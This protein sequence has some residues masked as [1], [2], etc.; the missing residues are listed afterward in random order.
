MMEGVLRAGPGSKKRYKLP[1]PATAGQSDERIEIVQAR[2][3]WRAVSGPRPSSPIGSSAPI[4]GLVIGWAALARLDDATFASA[5]PAWQAGRHS[6][7][8]ALSRTGARSRPGAAIT[9]ATTRCLFFL[10][11]GLR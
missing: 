9:S 3:R 11:R 7:P 1:D 4:R 5:S 10:K 2:P 8:G 6:G